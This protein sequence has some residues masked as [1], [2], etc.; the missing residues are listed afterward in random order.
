MV[1]FFAEYARVVVILHVIFA[2]IWVGGM[3]VVRFAVHQAMSSIE[4]KNIK[5]G[6]TIKMLGRFFQM[7]IVAIVMMGITGIMMLKSIPFE[8]ILLGIAHVKTQV[9][10][11]MALV[12]GYIYYRFTKAKSAYD[13]GDLAIC[14]GFLAP[15]PKYLILINI[16]LGLF[17]VML[18]VV[19]RGY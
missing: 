9:W 17:A 15:I 11:V 16:A 14:A 2:M 12:F 6:T 18:G 7:V 4:D 10:T 13:S 3:I 1:E 8:G 5:L 19:L